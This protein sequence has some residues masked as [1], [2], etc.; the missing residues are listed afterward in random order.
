M[1][2]FR[3]LIVAALI[4]AL[5][6][7]AATA[8]Q[9]TG[10]GITLEVRTPFGE[11]Y[12]PYYWLPLHITAANDGP[13]QTIELRVGQFA[14]QVDLPRGG[15][16][17]VV[18]Y[19]RPTPQTRLTIIARSNDKELTSSRIRLLTT[20]RPLVS[21]VGEIV[22]RPR[23]IE[24][25]QTDTTLFPNRAEG[26]EALNMV[27][28]DGRRRMELTPQQLQAIE[29]WVGSGGILLITGGSAMEHLLAT[30]PEELR[31]AYANVTDSATVSAAPLAALIGRSDDS[32]S[33]LAPR[34]LPQDSARVLA[35]AE[36]GRP[37]LVAKFVG[38]GRVVALAAPLDSDPLSTWSGLDQLWQQLIPPQNPLP[39]WDPSM[40]LS[41]IRDQQAPSVLSN[42]PA[43]DLPPLRWL[44]ILLG[45]YIALVGPL[46]YLVL[47]R[48]DRLAWAWVTIPALTLTFALLTYGIGA[49]Q[50]GSDLILNQVTV[51]EQV[52]GATARIHG[53][54]SIFSPIR[55]TYDLSGPGGALLRPL[56]YAPWGPN[57]SASTAIFQQNPGLIRDLRVNQWS[58]EMLGYNATIPWQGLEAALTLRE[59][60]ISGEVVNRS[61]Q[62]VH[63]VV[64]LVGWNILK[65][66]DLAPG[67]SAPIR[68]ELTGPLV[69]TGES[70]SSR[71]FNLDWGKFGPNGPPRDLQ[72]KMS[73][74]DL[75]VPAPLTMGTVRPILIGWLDE[76]PIGQLVP[77]NGQRYSRHQT[78]LIIA[79]PAIGFGSGPLTLG[80]AW[81][82]A[83]TNGF[84]PKEIC[85]TAGGPGIPLHQRTTQVT[86]ALPPQLVGLVP[87]SMMLNSV[88]D[89]PPFLGK[90]S[91]KARDWQI[92]E[93]VPIHTGLG[94]VEIAESQRFLTPGGEML[95]EI[96]LPP[97]VDQFGGFWSCFSPGIEITGRLP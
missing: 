59:S 70:I 74:V 3:S 37:L 30:L 17:E 55:A 68:L 71:I 10:S 52:S 83:T 49:G 18:L 46:S 62:T 91:I 41:Q 13:D 81:L 79:Y 2:R 19:T 40:N 32:G 33:I 53:Y 95:L 76:T 56:E 48:L 58:L 64:L 51:V 36:D 11:F 25:I 87:E 57:P 80:S 97:E 24:M 65:I 31:P 73:A 27:V 20:D 93:M 78:T 28:L 90:L 50:R 89:G 38:S 63:E 84:N 29:A 14:T 72:I 16:K 66:G 22:A 8:A 82:D 34:L 92:D 75:A 85:M 86:L 5:L 7:P 69:T 61:Q 77:A 67:A 43:L 88:A 1:D 9:N 21:V 15:R 96:E 26:L 45:V 4:L 42:L 60:Q 39:M 44:L 23:G 94:R 6:I 47:R 12:R 54:A 35:S